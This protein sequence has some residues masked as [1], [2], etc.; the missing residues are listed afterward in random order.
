M[1]VVWNKFGSCVLNQDT[2]LFTKYCKEQPSITEKDQSPF[3]NMY[4]VISH[5]VR[6]T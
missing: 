4:H 1:S 2:S 5:K 3:S 6:I